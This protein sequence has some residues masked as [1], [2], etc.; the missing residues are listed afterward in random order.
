[1]NVPQE[2]SATSLNLPQESPV[3]PENSL[4][5]SPEV[6]PQ[7]A[8]QSPR[9]LDIVPMI[10]EDNVPQKSSEK[11]SQPKTQQIGI[12]C[13]F[14]VDMEEIPSISTEP[15]QP[16]PVR[17]ELQA[18][19]EKYLLKSCNSEKGSGVMV[20]SDFESYVRSSLEEIKSLVS[21]KSG[22]NTNKSPDSTQ[23]HTLDIS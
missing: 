1:M 8:Q 7:L 12:E 6:F 16:E 9:S 14:D 23:K 17:L 15:V 13:A 3:S 11:V 10:S 2:S 4:R 19:I 22:E 5:K 21:S 18:P 20:K